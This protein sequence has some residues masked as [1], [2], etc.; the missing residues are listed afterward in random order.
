MDISISYILEFGRLKMNLE[1]LRKDVRSVGESYLFHLIYEIK[2]PYHIAE[3]DLIDLDE[4]IETEI[5]N[6]KFWL[7]KKCFIY[8]FTE[9]QSKSPNS[10]E[11]I[12]YKIKQS[13]QYKTYIEKIIAEF[14]T[15]KYFNMPINRKLYESDFLN[16]CKFAFVL[17]VLYAECIFKKSYFSD[18]ALV[19]LLSD[20]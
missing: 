1:T 16:S 6:L 4:T 12:L 17:G 13:S 20:K 19:E 11:L 14:N 2:Y 15:S 9:S 8:G 5:A 3:E 18:Q 7:M 10:F